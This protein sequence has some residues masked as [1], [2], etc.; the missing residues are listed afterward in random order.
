MFEVISELPH[1]PAVTQTHLPLAIAVA[2]VAF[3]PD[4]SESR[5]FAVA[6]KAGFQDGE[7]S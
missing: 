2:V 1:Q 6:G 7:E 3:S 4:K 5:G